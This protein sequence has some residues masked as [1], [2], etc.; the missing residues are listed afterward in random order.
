MSNPQNLSFEL[1]LRK[2]LEG[3]SSIVL[4]GIGNEI[5]C[6]DFVGV[7]I[8]RDLEGR[9]RKN[10]HLVECETVPESFMDEIVQ[11]QPTHVLL[12][13]AALLGINPGEVALYDP[14][15]VVDVPAISTHS[16][17]VRVFCD[18]VG[19]L[20]KARIALLLVEPRDT[21]FGEGL[22]SEVQC[23]AERVVK[24]LIEF[25]G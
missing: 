7:K 19:E 5:R 8:V 17:P 13:D 22:S 10:V 21:G 23:A 1:D 11:F 12:I 9:V 2:W 24:S 18:Y 16:L 3:A 20:T 6:D 25:L 14:C 15:K 4:A